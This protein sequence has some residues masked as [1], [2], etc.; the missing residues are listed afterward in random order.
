MSA[1]TQ[2]VRFLRANPYGHLYVTVGY[3]STAGLAW[4]NARTQ[5]RPVTLIIG[6]AKSAYFAKS[7]SADCSSALNS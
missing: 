5:G 7:T 6:T 3:A 1:S 4:L 2:I